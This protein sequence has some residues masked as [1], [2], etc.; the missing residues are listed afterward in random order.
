[1]PVQDVLASRFIGRPDNEILVDIYG[2]MSP[3]SEGQDL[4]TE[5]DPQVYDGADDEGP[6]PSFEP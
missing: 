3:F 1:M 2:A 4:S 6:E 5:P